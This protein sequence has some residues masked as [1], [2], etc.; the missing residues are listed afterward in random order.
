[1]SLATARTCGAPSLVAIELAS[2]SRIGRPL[3][4]RRKKTTWRLSVVPSAAL[5]GAARTA[6]GV[7][8]ASAGAAEACGAGLLA[9][10]ALSA[11]AATSGAGAGAA[12]GAGAT[13]LAGATVRA[14]PWLTILNA[15]SSSCSKAT[16]FSPSARSA[17]A[18]SHSTLMASSDRSNKSTVFLSSAAVPSRTM[19]SKSSLRWA[20]AS[21]APSSI[22]RLR[23]LSE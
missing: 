21:S 10:A 12:V 19:P 15:R 4:I 1:M 3:L 14:W 9:T 13:S 16:G 2:R 23:P 18:F 11:D 7:S 17:T 6:W 22:T 20:M 8:G 5:V